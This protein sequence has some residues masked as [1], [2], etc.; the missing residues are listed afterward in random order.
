MTKILDSDCSFRRRGS[1][2]QTVCKR[3]RKKAKNGDHGYKRVY[4]SFK[5]V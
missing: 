4:S 2:I 1:A 5:L 3:K